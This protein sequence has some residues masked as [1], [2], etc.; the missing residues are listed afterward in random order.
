VEFG[1]RSRFAEGVFGSVR[2]HYGDIPRGLYGSRL[3]P[4]FE[5]E[6]RL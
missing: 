5:V 1:L 3:Y 4:S 6:F 2:L